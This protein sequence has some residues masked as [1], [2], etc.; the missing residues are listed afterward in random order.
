MNIPNLS[1]AHGGPA[2]EVLEPRFMLDGMLG[3]EVT[4]DYLIIAAAHQ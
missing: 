4:V 1:S 3:N 2:F